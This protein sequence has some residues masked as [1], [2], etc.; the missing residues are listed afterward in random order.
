MRIEVWRGGEC[1]IARVE[2]EDST[3]L[4][5][6]VDANRSTTSSEQ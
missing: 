3:S 4:N 6:I 5:T 1:T 2:V